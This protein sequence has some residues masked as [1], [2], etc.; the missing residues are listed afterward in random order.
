M[1]TINGTEV[2]VVGVLGSLQ[3]GGVEHVM[4]EAHP[5]DKGRGFRVP[6]AVSDIEG[7]LDAVKEALAIAD[8]YQPTIL[9]HGEKPV[10]KVFTKMTAGIAVANVA[11]VTRVEFDATPVVKEKNKKGQQRIKDDDFSGL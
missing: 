6:V 4:C 8:G 11:G 10:L 2:R 3:S 1:R 5:G 7:G 9:M